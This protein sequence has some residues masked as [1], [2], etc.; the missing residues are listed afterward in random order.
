MVLH[1]ENIRV[2]IPAYFALELI[3]DQ[4]AERVIHIIVVE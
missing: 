2:F 1:R 4:K 3:I